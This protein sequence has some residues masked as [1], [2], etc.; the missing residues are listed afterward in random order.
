MELVIRP[1]SHCKA[2]L[3]RHQVLEI[4]NG[5]AKLHWSN[6]AVVLEK[7]KAYSDQILI[8]VIVSVSNFQDDART[9]YRVAKLAVA[10]QNRGVCGFGTAS[11]P[12]LLSLLRDTDFLRCVWKR[13]LCFSEY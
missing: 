5:R 12:P 1:T 13:Y 3:S 8:G 11:S 4:G 10:Y 7:S 2:G 9:W 6:R